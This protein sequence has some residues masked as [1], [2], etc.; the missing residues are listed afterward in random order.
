MTTEEAEAIRTACIE[1]VRLLQNMSE[2]LA[3]ASNA[4]RMCAEAAQAIERDLVTISALVE[5]DDA[6]YAMDHL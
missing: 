4:T 3:I 5:E 6:S 1:L 2:A